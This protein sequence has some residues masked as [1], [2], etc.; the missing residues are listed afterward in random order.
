AANAEAHHHELLDAEVIHQTELV[1]GV[2]IPRPIDLERAGGLAAV[3]V[4]QVRCDAAVLSF[5]LLDRIEGIAT[6]QAGDR[7][8]QSPT[9]DEQQRKAGAGLL[10]VNADLAFFVEGQTRPS[11]PTL[12]SKDARRCGHC[13]RRGTCCQYLASL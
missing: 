5:E 13:R 7:R 4:A 11:L 9:G 6:V 3:G 10:I 12:L 2:R 8:V 1:I